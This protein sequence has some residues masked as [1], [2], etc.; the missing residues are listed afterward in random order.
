MAIP[1][2]GA[3]K[4][5]KTML[6]TV[7]S[8]FGGE[9]GVRTPGPPIGGQRFSRPPHSTTLPLLHFSLRLR[10]DNIFLTFWNFYAKYTNYQII[11]QMNYL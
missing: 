8:G 3:S 7:F 2:G 11:R 10:K 1:W 9:G 4:P 5:E 6:S